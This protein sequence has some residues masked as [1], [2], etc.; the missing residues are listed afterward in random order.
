[1]QGFWLAVLSV[2]T[3]LVQSHSNIFLCS[4]RFAYIF[5]IYFFVPFGLQARQIQSISDCQ[6]QQDHSVGHSVNGELSNNLRDTS[7]ILAVLLVAYFFGF[8]SSFSTNRFR[9]FRRLRVF[10]PGVNASDSIWCCCVC[11]TDF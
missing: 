11:A 8:N 10:H 5:S 2:F 4:F 7:N 9:R 6:S 1:M 3:C